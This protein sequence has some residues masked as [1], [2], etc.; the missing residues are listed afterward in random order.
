MNEERN[1]KNGGLLKLLLIIAAVLMI[2]MLLWKRGVFLSDNTSDE[3]EEQTVITN[4][5]ETD[6]TDFRI[7]KTE[8]IALQ[9]EVKQLRNEVDRL[10]ANGAKPASATPEKTT[11]IPTEPATATS[12][13]VTAFNPNAVTLSNYA[14]DWM[15]SEA[16]VAFKNNL[17]KPVTQIEGKIIYYDMNN[18]ML[19][20]QDFNKAVSIEPGFVKSI[21]LNGYGYREHYAY[22][23]SAVI[24][25]NP[26][27]KYKVKFELKSY[28]TK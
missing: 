11:A 20:Y 22:Y 2:V 7:S 6:A 24:P 4:H 18:N 17:D 25:T 19:D 5:T 12:N 28:K 26:D 16:T 27:R 21:T 14:H 23:K 1:E 15:R 9:K 8:W 13:N 10:K 3:V